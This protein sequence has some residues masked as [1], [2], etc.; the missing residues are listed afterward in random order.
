[1]GFSR[2]RATLVVGAVLRGISSLH[3]GHSHAYS[4]ALAAATS[5]PGEAWAIGLQIA[6]EPPISPPGDDAADST[7]VRSLT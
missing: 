6:R 4:A 1:M 2:A 7:V 3:V 5:R